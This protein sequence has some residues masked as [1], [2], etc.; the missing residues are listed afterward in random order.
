M[1]RAESEEELLEEAKEHAH[2]HG[3]EPTPE[4]LEMVRARIKEE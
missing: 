1:I 4:L 2:E 3:L